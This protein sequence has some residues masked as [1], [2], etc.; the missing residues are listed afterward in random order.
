MPRRSQKRS[1]LRRNRLATATLPLAPTPRW[2]TGHLFILSRRPRR[3]LGALH[4]EFGDF[5][6]LR[7]G[8]KRILL[9]SDPA[10][11][12]E[13]LHQ[14]PRFCRTLRIAATSRP[15]PAGDREGE[16]WLRQRQL[17]AGLPSRPH[18]TN[19]AKR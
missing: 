8:M 9:V 16:F 19:T 3:L 18:P 1:S 17:A 7:I 15:G 2:F 12:E 4:R 13:V 6:P 5:V 10:A 14:E 11:I